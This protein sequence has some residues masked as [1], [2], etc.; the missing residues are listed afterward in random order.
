MFNPEYRNPVP[1][2][3]R[4]LWKMELFYKQPFKIQCFIYFKYTI[5]QPKRIIKKYLFISWEWAYYKYDHIARD[6]VNKAYW[7]ENQKS[8]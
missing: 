2:E 5:H 4:P 7:K 3:W 8:V 1:P 6:I